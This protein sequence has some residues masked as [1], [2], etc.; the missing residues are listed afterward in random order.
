MF[1]LKRG[2]APKSSKFSTSAPM[3]RHGRQTD[4]SAVAFDALI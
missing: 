4:L 1:A 2:A 3:G